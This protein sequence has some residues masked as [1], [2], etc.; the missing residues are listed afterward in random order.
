MGTLLAQTVHFFAALLWAAAALAALVGLGTLAIAIVA[1]VLVNALF[2]TIQLG[3]TDRAVDRLLDMVPRRCRVRRDGVITDIEALEVVVGDT[4]LL[5]AGDRVAADAIVTAPVS[6]DM[7]I[8]TGERDPVAVEPGELVAAGTVVAAGETTATVV[9]IGAATRFAQVVDLAT[10]HRA[11]TSPLTLELHRT[12]RTISA[13]AVGAGTAMGVVAVAIGQS[14]RDAAVLAIGVAVA[15]VPEGLLPTLTLSLALG[16][17]RMARRGALVR[18]LDAVESLG[19]TSFL[20][21][22]KTG[23]V[24]T[25]RLRVTDTWCGEGVDIASV[26]SRAHRA[27]GRS[28]LGLEDALHDYVESLGV[29]IE[30][31]EAEDPELARTPFDPATRMASV[32]LV[33]GLVSVGAPEAIMSRAATDAEAHRALD[34]MTARGLRVLAVACSSSD[35]LTTVALIGFEDP[36]R[37]GVGAAVSQWAHLGVRTAMITG[38]HPATAAAI[39]RAIGLGGDTGP[40]VVVASDLPRDPEACGEL[41]DRDGIV[42]ARAS[43][44]DKVIIAQALRS[45]GHVVAMT[46]DGVNDVPALHL[47]DVGVAMGRSGSDAARE[48]ADLILLDDDVTT[49]VAAIIEG[50][51]AY[52]NIRRFLTYHLTDNVAEVAPVI[53]WAVSG[54]RIPL[55]LGVLQILALDL[56]T[57]TLSAVALGAEAPRDSTPREPTRG[58]LL[59]R[60]VMTRAFGRL[61]PTEVAVEA[62]A[63]AVAYCWGASDA[64]ASGA[65]FVAVVLCQSANA[66]ACRSDTAPPWALGWLSNRFLVIAVI[67]EAILALGVVAIPAI[68]EHLGHRLPPGPVWVVVIAGALGLLGVDAADKARRVRSFGRDELAAR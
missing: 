13:V 12:V 14:A 7:A 61:G 15:L 9:A 56:G 45:R 62:A 5:A 47:A 49:I 66:W 37:R 53:A 32:E 23:T 48:A 65:V 67:L 22:D 19:S 18:H 1:V 41:V 27:V 34:A 10:G 24:T 35:H 40:V 68:A 16:A 44:H 64:G 17:E 2:T 21:L 38:D 33:S 8:L 11:P 20:C 54:G 3:R 59:D 31:E 43:P 55:A 39:A 46:G 51:S 30:R 42:I 50:R 29:L 28:D 63:F 6:V 36:P 52:T 57:D 58:R 26:A 25:G 60:R 4:I